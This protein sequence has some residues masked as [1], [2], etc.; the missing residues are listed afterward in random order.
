MAESERSC[1]Y[2]GLLDPDDGCF[3]RRQLASQARNGGLTYEQFKDYAERTLSMAGKCT[4]AGDLVTDAEI[5]I[6]LR[7]VMSTE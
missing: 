3:L 6:L 2:R 7:S 4:R 5:E 1:E